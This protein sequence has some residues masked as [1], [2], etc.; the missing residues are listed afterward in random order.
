MLTKLKKLKVELKRPNVLVVIYV[1]YTCKPINT[2]RMVGKGVNSHRRID[3]NESGFI[4]NKVDQTFVALVGEQ[5]P[6]QQHYNK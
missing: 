5:L 2:V 3:F 6:F 1:I 4:N